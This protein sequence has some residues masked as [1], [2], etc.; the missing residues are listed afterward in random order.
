[1]AK[2]KDLSDLGKLLF[3]D[4]PELHQATPSADAAAGP[5]YDLRV[6]LDRKK[7]NKEVTAIAGF[8][9]SDPEGEALCKQLKN[10]CGAGGSFKDGEILIQGNHRERVKTWLEQQGHRV[11]LAGG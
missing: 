6:W 7:G 5:R 3:P 8:G 10:H 11:K 9:G 2:S 1:M 4:Q